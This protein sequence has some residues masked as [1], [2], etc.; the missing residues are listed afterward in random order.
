MFK[1]SEKHEMDKRILECEY[2]RYSPSE[3]ST[4]NTPNS[5]IFIN[6]PRKDSVGCLLGSLLR[7]NSDV[8]HAATNNGYVDGNDTGLGNSV[9]GIKQ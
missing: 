6:F 9:D 2:I 1:L 3:I 5:Q 8:L 7:L 4:V